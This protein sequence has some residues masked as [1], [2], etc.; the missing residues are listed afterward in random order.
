VKF[1]PLADIFPLMEGEEFKA[2]V[3]DIKANGLREPITTF[4]GKILEGRNRY[5]ACLR[6]KIEPLRT[7][8]MGNEADA[9]AFVASRNIHR[10]HLTPKQRREAIAKLLKLHPEKS[11]REIGRLTKTDNKT[12]AVVRAEQ[13]RR[14]EIPHVS[15]RTD[16]KGRKQPATKRK[17]NQP[18]P[19][20]VKHDDR[21]ISPELGKRVG[22]FADKLIRLDRELARELADLILQR[23]V[24]ERLWADLDTGID[25]EERAS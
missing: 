25:L 20:P 13:E 9:A 11:N 10:R 23:G 22:R 14:E 17:S 21:I 8:F 12:V 19:K 1:H 4:E 24:A 7:P 15:T 18:A 6:L 5:R 16:T 3:A 2:F